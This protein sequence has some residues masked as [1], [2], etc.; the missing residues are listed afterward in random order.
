[1][2]LSSR[3][4]P[5]PQGHN[6]CLSTKFSKTCR[7]SGLCE[8]SRICIDC[9]PTAACATRYLWKKITHLRSMHQ[10]DR[11]TCALLSYHALTSV[12]GYSS[13]GTF[14]PAN[15]FST[16]DESIAHDLLF[17][18]SS[19][20]K[21]EAE[22]QDLSSVITWCMETCRHEALHLLAAS[23]LDAPKHP[24]QLDK[25]VFQL[26]LFAREL[27]HS[28]SAP[29]TLQRAVG[30]NDSPPAQSSSLLAVR[31]RGPPI[32]SPILASAQKRL[33]GLRHSVARVMSSNI[34]A[35]T[36]A[37][38]SELKTDGTL[39]D[40]QQVE[41]GRVADLAPAVV[42][43]TN[44]SPDSR[45]DPADSASQSPSNLNPSSRAAKN[46]GSVAKSSST[47]SEPSR[48][49]ESADV[50]PRQQSRKQEPGQQQQQ[51]QP[52]DDL[53]RPP[54]SR[55]L[56]GEDDDDY[57]D[58]QQEV[59][60]DVQED[61]G[62]GGSSSTQRLRVRRP[63]ML[64]PSSDDDDESTGWGGERNTGS[65]SE[66]ASDLP[67]S[68]GTERLPPHP[69]TLRLDPDSLYSKQI[70]AMPSALPVVGPWILSSSAHAFPGTD[71]VANIRAN[72]WTG[73]HL[74]LRFEYIA[75]RSTPGSAPQLHLYN[76]SRVARKRLSLAAA[77]I[78][79][80]KLL[81]GDR[82][83]PLEAGDV[84][85]LG[86]HPK[87][88]QQ[89]AADHS[90]NKSAEGKRG[91]SK[92]LLGSSRNSHRVLRLT[93]VD[94][95]EGSIGGM[96]G[97]T[98]AE[99]VISQ[100]DSGPRVGK[101]AGGEL[102]GLKAGGSERSESSPSGSP[103]VIRGVSPVKT[104]YV[105]TA[106]KA[107]CAKFVREA[108][109]RAVQVAAGARGDAP[110]TSSAATGFPQLRDLASKGPAEAFNFLKSEV[111]RNPS[112]TAAWLSWA[113]LA[114]RTK[115]HQI[116]R[117]L[118]RAAYE[119]AEEAER[120]AVAAEAEAQAADQFL[121]DQLFSSVRPEHRPLN[122]L[123]LPNTARDNATSSSQ[124]PAGPFMGSGSVQPAI[125]PDAGSVTPEVKRSA[126]PLNKK[127]QPPAPP[128]RKD[129]AGAAA[130]TWQARR[131][132]MQVLFFWAQHEWSVGNQGSARHLWRRAADL[133][134]KHPEGA[135]AGGH[136]PVM[137]A[138]VKAE[139][140]KD[141]VGNARILLAEAL[142]RSPDV[143]Q[144]Y[145]L[146]GQVELV[147]GNLELAKG[148]C[149]QAFE[150]D[151]TDEELYLIWPK[152]LAAMG[153][154][155][156]AETLLERALE[157]HPKSLRLLSAYASIAAKQ[158]EYDEARELH[159][160]ALR[161]DP[162][163][164]LSLPNRAAWAALEVDL[165][166]LEA[167]QK[168][169][170]EGMSRYPLDPGCLL[171][172]ARIQRLLGDYQGAYNV[173]ERMFKQQKLK[174]SFDMDIMME[175][176]LLYR[177]LGERDLARSLEAHLR[178]MRRLKEM[179][180]GGHSG[181]EAWKRFFEEARSPSRRDL[182]EKAHSRK[183][184]LGLWEK[185][186]RPT[187]MPGTPAA[188]QVRQEQLKRLR[189]E[190]EQQR[191]QQEE[192][193]ERRFVESQMERQ[194]RRQSPSRRGHAGLHAGTRV[195]G[196]LAVRDSRGDD[197]DGEL[198]ADMIDFLQRS[199]NNISDVNDEDS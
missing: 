104:S 2:S 25:A 69:L 99:D 100:Q 96:S 1:M 11:L 115:R 167:G 186:G 7:P 180:H 131:R 40:P 162:V 182:A 146:A 5:V 122:P 15:Y 24:Y 192:E 95:D 108:A 117:D 189:E 136:A 179:K 98:L 72:L 55:L 149:T 185:A 80:Q 156:R 76:T 124:R 45:M 144:L 14:G 13:Q 138:W 67:L 64:A 106:L 176:A 128:V 113:Q 26:E 105:K 36:M 74:A 154:P 126:P 166:N 68:P 91:W 163:G 196:A 184:E 85:E 143:Q 112:N 17:A 29:S 63:K 187:K 137:L 31:P 47:S 172:L 50:L 78:N 66:R 157:V 125:T 132:C 73:A 52:L 70:K 111:A 65:W 90:V 121:R 71:C 56:P 75:N 60:S 193:E 19:V 152:V 88:L 23:I 53:P 133:S 21:L 10:V 8:F 30:V 41:G 173:L 28:L 58:V 34:R 4:A 139:F 147:A 39:V 150:M 109:E 142:R 116:A 3:S 174:D 181:W 83:R 130:R 103:S 48:S 119:C 12:S 129:L 57:S 16:E 170:E 61:P 79:G 140:E 62:G 89:G 145:V 35:D 86:V 135:G 194:G 148:F 38:S 178:S 114:S 18:F 161:I 169:V 158:G 195:G 177:A 151:R 42:T 27:L 81:P 44:T 168:L 197:V 175:R 159:E 127:W 43:D 51:Q 97:A 46:G 164:K 118:F 20:L 101:T 190:E 171:V 102:V 155:G 82:G 123:P 165:D 93:V 94:A 134:Y 54:F 22:G 120:E 188:W 199:D 92:D 37:A 153:Q 160:R 77:Y 6:I 198:E 87:D 110:S 33:S 141:N 59:Y 191:R 9:R 32:G 49:A 84:I 183:V 107:H